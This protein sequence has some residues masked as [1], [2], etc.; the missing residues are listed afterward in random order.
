MFLYTLMSLLPLWIAYL[1]HRQ[2]KARKRSIDETNSTASRSSHHQS[3]SVHTGITAN[4]ES[5]HPHQIQKE[6]D[7]SGGQPITSIKGPGVP[8]EITFFVT[9]PPSK[10]IPVLHTGTKYKS[11]KRQLAF[12]LQNMTW[13]IRKPQSIYTSK[14]KLEVNDGGTTPDVSS[15]GTGTITV[16]TDNVN[17]ANSAVTSSSLFSKKSESGNASMASSTHMD[18]PITNNT[19]HDS[20][21]VWK[22]ADKSKIVPVESLLN[23]SAFVPDKCATVEINFVNSHASPPSKSTSDNLLS[24]MVT[25]DNW[26]THTHDSSVQKN[27]R[28]GERN[29][30]SDDRSLSFEEESFDDSSTSASMLGT[31]ASGGGGVDNIHSSNAGASRHNSRTQKD[32]GSTRT[33]RT[34]SKKKSRLK[35]ETREFT[36]DTEL[37][38][39]A[40]QTLFLAMRIV[41]R[42]ILNL[43][44]ALELVHK[45]S[46]AYDGSGYDDGKGGVALDDVLRC[47][48]DLPFVGKRIERVYQYCA[49]TSNHLDPS[50]VAGLADQSTTHSFSSSLESFRDDNNDNNDNDNDKGASS[51]RGRADEYNS[52]RMVLGYVDFFRL[53]IPK[54]LHGTPYATPVAECNLYLSDTE[55]DGIE[56]H[57]A[58]VRQMVTMRQRVAKAAVRVSAYVNAMKIVNEGWEIP[59]PSTDHSQARKRLSFDHEDLNLEHDRRSENEYYDPMLSRKNQPAYA[60]VGYNTVRLSPRMARMDSTDPVDFIPTLRTIIDKNP[61]SD[62]FVSSLL[63]KKERLITILLF[64]K[65]LPKGIDEAF[66]EAFDRFTSGSAELRNDILHLSSAY[67]E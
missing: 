23:V 24:N 22:K 7:P 1:A 27:K 32:K 9:T 62:F 37:D 12:N 31:F 5:D 63:H 40:F 16:G 6:S 56:E 18:P 46:E 20:D 28:G 60:L 13:E 45:S 2:F 15:S 42:D 33:P 52:K 48:G 59:I 26:K 17:S 43:Y 44:N 58:R 11:I 30:M 41:G 10:N 64:V 67:G 34:G 3:R 38:A 25:L 51:T 39:G 66:D 35:E 4:H 57:H 21:I 47:L 14:A 50:P 36:F 65:W 55:L 49:D 8:Q 53:F 54:I 29:M 61:Q 19:L